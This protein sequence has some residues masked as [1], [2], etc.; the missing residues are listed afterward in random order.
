M[1][2]FFVFFLTLLFLF[3]LGYLR[4]LPIFVDLI[5][6]AL[7]FGLLAG[8]GLDSTLLWVAS[9]MG[10]MFAGF[11]IAILSGIV[12]VRLLSDQG[13]L[14]VMVRG[15]H[16]KVK[17][18]RASSGILSFILSVPIT[19]PV[20]TYAMLSPVLKRL[21]P[22]KVRANMLLYV[23]ATCAIISYIVIFPTPFTQPLASAF[24]PDSSWGGF[25]LVTIPIALILLF[26]VIAVAGFWSRSSA[27]K[28]GQ[29]A[30]ATGPSAAPVSGGTSG[31][32]GG[33]A[34]EPVIP[35]S[36]HLNAWAPFIAMAVSIPAGLFILGLS[37]VAIL[38]FIMLAGLLVALLLCPQDIRMNSF[39]SGLKT[40]GPVIFDICAAGAIG[41][42]VV[43]SG[44]AKSALAALV[45]VLPDILIPFI[46]AVILATIQG[47]RV[48]TAVVTAQVIGATALIN[49]INPL[50]LILMVAA[51]SCIVCHVTDPF[52]HFVRN[53][54]G[55]DTRTV[56]RNYT[57]PL[58][59]VGVVL[60]IV[61]LAL[62]VF[63]FPYHEN[64][65]LAMMTGA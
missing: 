23:A 38:Q 17:N 41:T 40:A 60:F 9:G 35:L 3:I 1:D 13:L 32:P 30:D 6:G 10:S 27:G 33:S 52:F 15:I 2:V 20:V 56:I 58:A 61:A 43:K 36:R 19:C 55:D 26:L 59:C 65:A 49:E 50:P 21:D 53:T 8:A 37:H 54:T 45:P 48:T 25:N 42:V 11:A 47:S 22:E 44:L 5:L 63:V 12:I 46:I 64:A 24:A 62:A 28:S 18:T 29:E 31:E 34:G 57:L 16:A 39:S 4:K 51:G 14:D 7:F